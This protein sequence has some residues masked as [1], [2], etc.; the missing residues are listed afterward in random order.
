VGPRTVENL[1]FHDSR[2]RNLT[3]GEQRDEHTGYGRVS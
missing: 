3:G 1:E 2:H